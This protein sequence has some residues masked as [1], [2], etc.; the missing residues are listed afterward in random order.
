M[1]LKR[2]DLVD[3]SGLP[4]QL[5]GILLCLAKKSTPTADSALSGNRGP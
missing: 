2:S 5:V 4:E 3:V 1:G